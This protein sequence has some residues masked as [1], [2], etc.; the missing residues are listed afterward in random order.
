MV[1]EDRSPVEYEYESI[2]ARAELG[3]RSMF[4]AWHVAIGD[5]KGSEVDHINEAKS[6]FEDAVRR[7]NVRK[8]ELE[9]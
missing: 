1:E 4:W 7:L 8:K 3:I 6:Y 5:I 2:S 9:S